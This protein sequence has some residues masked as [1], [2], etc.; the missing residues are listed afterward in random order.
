MDEDQFK[1]VKIGNQDMDKDDEVK[2]FE[3]YHQID[4]EKTLYADK[5]ANA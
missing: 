5:K 2:F 4:T 1:K 3:L